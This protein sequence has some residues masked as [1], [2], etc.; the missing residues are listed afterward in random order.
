[1]TKLCFIGIDGV[2]WDKASQPDVAP[3]LM[4]LATEGSVTPMWMVPPT[5]SGPGWATLLT[6]RPH[7]ET[8]VYDN[9]FVA[10]RL[11]YCPDLLSQMW[12]RDYTTRTMAA[13]TWRQLADPHG[14]APVIHTRP[15]QIRAGLHQLHI[16]DGETYGC[17]RADEEVEAVAARVIREEGPDGCFIH[18][19]GVDEAG[20]NYGSE[21]SEYTDAIGRIDENIRCIWKAVDERVRL[22]DEDWLI[23]IATDHGHKPEGGHGED[24]E[25]VRRSF[26][27][28]NRFGRELP[29]LGD[30]IKPTDVT[31]LL[32]KLT[33]KS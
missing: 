5:D 1:M 27:V 31:P 16:R 6:G 7:E 17:I 14:R 25:I 29:D 12:F 24:E 33:E 22:Y 21:G 9:E 19:E 20:H 15:D 30:E 10:H 11:G 18:L 4:K 28:L 8:N 32:L 23:C 26:L 2:R 3:W 13:V